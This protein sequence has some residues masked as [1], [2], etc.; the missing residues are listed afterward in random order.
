MRVFFGTL[1]TETN[2]F[3][4]IATGVTSFDRRPQPAKWE[5]ALQTFAARGAEVVGGFYAVAEPSGTIN[6][7]AYESLRD[8]LLAQIAAARPVDIV[9][10]MLHGAM[11]AHG[12]DDCEGDTLARIRSLVP[13]GVIGATI[14]PHCHLTPAMV[15]NSDLLIAYK[16]YPHVDAIACANELSVKL[17]AIMDGQIKPVPSLYDCRTIS[18]YHTDREPMHS[19]VS[20][21]RALEGHEDILSISIAHGFPWGDVPEAGT[22]VL[23]YTNDS[24]A[25]GEEVARTIANRLDDVRG[26]TYSPLIDYREAISAAL[27]LPG[28]T[29]IADYA[30]NPGGGA[31]GDS[32]FLLREL[33][34]RKAEHVAIGALWDPMAVNVALQAGIGSNVRLRIGGKT[35]SASGD[36]IDLDVRIVSAQHDYR[37]PIFDTPTESVYGEVVVARLEP[38]IDIVLCS[39]RCQ[40]RARALFEG[41]NIKLETKNVIVVKSSHHFAYDFAPFADRVF[42]ASSPGALQMDFANLPYYR[43][44]RPIWPLDEIG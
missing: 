1:W 24:P 12:Y 32:T 20:W 25:K 23:V 39:V 27:S 43:V 33:L 30:D 8:E 19:I 40:T 3:G 6:R 29:V 5:V 7:D 41:L 35:S 26:T 42:H 10:L 36:P 37:V 15:S 4:P 44:R 11:V 17:V 21:I 31:S 22:K 38:D 16:E 18:M 2:T 28:R 9:I 34:D 14:D 13:S